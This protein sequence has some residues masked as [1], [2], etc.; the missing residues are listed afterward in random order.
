MDQ[1]KC[2]L[3]GEVTAE[4]FLKQLDEIIDKHIGTDE[5]KDHA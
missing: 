2:I 3:D 4:E 1:E 5:S